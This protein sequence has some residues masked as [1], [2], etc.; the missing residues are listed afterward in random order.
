MYLFWHTYMICKASLICCQ[1]VSE[2]YNKNLTHRCTITGDNLR[3]WHCWVHTFCAIPENNHTLPHRRDW[4]FL[5][6]GSGGSVRL[7]ILKKCMKLNW[8]FQRGGGLGNNPL[9]EVQIFMEL[10]DSKLQT[11]HSE[12]NFLKKKQ[13]FFAYFS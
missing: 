4:N 13:T 7:T 2:R 3:L 8:N 12:S 10:G 11:F 9:E 5:N 1:S 6:G